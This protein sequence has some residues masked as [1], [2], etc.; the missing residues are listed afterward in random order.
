MKYI[1]HMKSQTA[2]FSCQKFLTKSLQNVKHLSTMMAMMTM[3]WP[4][5]TLMVMMYL[6]I[7]LAQLC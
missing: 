5:Q 6:V 2:Q 1:K 3:P 4:T 7:A